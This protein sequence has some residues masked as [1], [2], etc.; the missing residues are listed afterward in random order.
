M[1]TQSSDFGGHGIL[2]STAH[3]S[4]ALEVHKER[5]PIKG[6][7]KSCGE[8][9]KSKHCASLSVSHQCCFVNLKEESSLSSP[10]ST[11]S[12]QTISIACMTCFMPAITMDAGITKMNEMDTVLTLRDLAFIRGDDLCIQL[13]L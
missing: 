7:E 2:R 1:V 4:P 11:S 6:S 5:Q 9:K 3:W 8:H 13:Q 10:K 12:F